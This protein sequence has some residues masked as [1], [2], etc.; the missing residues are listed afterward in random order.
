MPLP[1]DEQMKLLEQ[2]FGGLD[3]SKIQSS[4]T[5]SPQKTGTLNT[6]VAPVQIDGGDGFVK[7]VA[8][9]IARPFVKLGV[10][11]KSA[12]EAAANLI[13]AATSV[14][15][16]QAQG[17][18]NKAAEA[19]KGDEVKGF[20]EVTPVT[21]RKPGEAAG[22]ALDVGS[23]VI[24]GGVAAGV[25]KSTLKGLV[26]EGLKIGLREGALAGGLAGAGKTLQDEDANAGDVAVNTLGGTVLGG[27]LGGVSGA[28]LPL[29]RNLLGIG[30]KI[31]TSTPGAVSRV[32]KNVAE[33]VTDSVAKSNRIAK[34]PAAE[35][36]VVRSGI[37]E[38]V[39]QFIKDVSNSDK[40]AF[41]RM[42]NIG[43]KKSE[44]IAVQERPIEVAGES[45]LKR[46]NVLV[47]AKDAIGKKLKVS[48]AN[49]PKDPINIT[50]IYNDF[51][52]DLTGLGLQIRNGQ[53]RT[54][55]RVAE[56]DTKFFDLMLER[57]RPNKNG[58]VLRTPQNIHATRGRIFDEVNLAKA[59][60]SPFSD[61]VEIFAERYRKRLM[62]VLADVDETYR[63]SNRQLAQIIPALQ[64]FTRLI[65]YKGN[66]DDIVTK[67]L[68]TGEVSFRLLGNAQDR[69][70]AVLQEIDR[71]SRILGF[72]SDDNVFNQVLFADLL[73]NLFG[74]S[75][76]R[77]IRGAMGR[78][79]LDADAERIAGATE[80]ATGGL[81]SAIATK[82]KSVMG[83]SDK[84]K[85]DAFER[86]LKSV[87]NIKQ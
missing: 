5:S 45:F 10:S 2:T 34:L 9:D 56:S 79:A 86:F 36:E 4:K 57:I 73:E 66:L 40:N 63:T 7:T 78:A 70:M 46:V 24:G 1:K 53:I 15:K 62:D 29:V 68:K 22:V 3:V 38:S 44:N 65:G 71:L 77:S 33:N 74:T 51:V 48:V 80:A 61:T 50:S 55:G 21:I 12:G 11:I 43:K 64:D 82:L 84:A 23:T 59:R 28:A 17:Y 37:D 81:Y 26:K 85:I 72:K 42:F 47:K 30:T 60:Q 14:N 54:T 49:M 27:L 58:E 31:V 83:K 16:E 6:S 25:G 41:L 32:S 52:D 18:I 67:K 19:L 87:I 8:K 35:A 13:R 76:T 39:T 69:P 20:G 75:Q